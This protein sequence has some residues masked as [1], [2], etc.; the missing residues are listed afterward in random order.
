MLFKK[1]QN[2]NNTKNRSEQQQQKEWRVPSPKLLRLRSDRLDGVEGMSVI[3][4]VRNVPSVHCLWNYFLSAPK[5]DFLTIQLIN[6]PLEKP[7][8]CRKMNI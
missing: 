8:G 7:I 6:S 2:N 5:M 1:I 4:K 3:I